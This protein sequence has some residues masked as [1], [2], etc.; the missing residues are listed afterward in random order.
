MRRVLCIGSCSK[1]IFFPTEEG[2]VIETPDDLRSQTKVAFELGGKFRSRDRFEAVGGVAANVAQGLARLG[3]PAAVYS[4]VGRDDLG[5]WIKRSLDGAGVST[6]TLDIDPSVKTDLSAIV[7]I[8]QTG[9]RIIFHNRD[10]NEKLSI[11]PEALTGFDWF[12]V[13]AL[14]GPWQSNFDMIMRVAAERNVRIAFNPGQ[15]NLKEDPRRLLDAL[16]QV[17]ALFLNKDEA[18]ELL[19]SSGVEKRAEQLNDENYLVTTLRGY[20]PEVVALTDGKR[21]AWVH[22]GKETWHADPFEPHGL[23][24]TTG[25]GDAFGAGL[26]AAFLSGLSLETALR[27][28]IA[29][30]GSV[31]GFYGA[32]EGLLDQESILP[33][34]KNVHAERI[35]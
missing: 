29:N 30:G 27:Y 22:D 33:Y 16:K 21:G 14:N 28:G 11:R 7:V 18:L 12:Y 31:V 19:L 34:L 10:A 32:S 9:D 24:D 5:T 4:K 13:S 35:A 23:V 17:H 25:A 20:G 6:E 15:H 3:L 2:V 26:F 1:D 8:Q